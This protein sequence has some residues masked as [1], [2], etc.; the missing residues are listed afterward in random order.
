MST[1]RY[2]A[3]DAAP[4]CDARAVTPSDTDD[5]AGGPARALYVGG[6]GTVVLVTRSG[7]TVTFVGVPAGS[8]LPVDTKRVKTDTTAT[9]L[10]ALF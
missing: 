8:I 7:N 10:V 5:I 2:T 3:N 9:N 4:A 1:L 6:A